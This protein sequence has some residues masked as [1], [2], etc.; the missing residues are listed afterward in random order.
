MS[1]KITLKPHEKIIIAGA[2]VTNGEAKCKLEI[3]NKVPILR[4]KDILTEADTDT[5]CRK[6]YYVVQ[7]MYI[8]EKNLKIY[9]KKY[10]ELVHQLID[11]A[12]RTLSLI[13][14]I[15]EKILKAQ[16]YKAL[17]LTKQLIS[18]EEEI[19]KSV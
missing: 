9:H 18:Y 7:L 17:K 16:Y 14:Q 2:V 13:D 12:P 15:S 6:I 8:D 11:A 10:W 3:H 5:H 1:L 4:E 19:L